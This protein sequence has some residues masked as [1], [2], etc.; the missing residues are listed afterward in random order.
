MSEIRRAGFLVSKIHQLSGRLLAQKTRKH[1]LDI[2]PAQGRI[3]FALWDQE[4][5]T[6][7]DLLFKTQLGKSTLSSMVKRLEKA[8]YLQR[9]DHPDDDR[10]KRIQ[11]V[12]K[13]PELQKKYQSIAKEMNQIYYNGISEKDILQFEKTLEKVLENLIDASGK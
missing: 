7:Q 10:K 9:K 1:D 12:K 4:E 13:D 2:S 5:M 3:I 6:F 11:L 8:K